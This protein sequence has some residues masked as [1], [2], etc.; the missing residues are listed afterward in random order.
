MSSFSQ[1]MGY[2]P[3]RS[4]VQ[5]E[6][7][8]AETRVAMWNLLVIFREILEDRIYLQYQNDGYLQQ[9]LLA[10]WTYTFKEARDEYPGD[11]KVWQRMKAGVLDFSWFDAL[12]VL[13]NFAKDI[14]R[15]QPESESYQFWEGFAEAANDRF[16]QY[17][18]GYRFIETEITPV[19]STEE[20]EAVQEALDAVG[21]L[22]GARHALTRAVDLLANRQ[23]PDYPNSM[24][25]SISAVESVIRMVS[26]ETD[27][28]A[29][30]KKL[31][32]AGL[33][34]HPALKQAWMKMYGYTSDESGV[35]HG[36]IEAATVDQALAK[37]MLVT[38]SG[39]V[40][41][42]IEEGRKAGLL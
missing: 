24:K 27:L 26:G 41:Y 13:E 32:S 7:L 9:V 3:T 28:A 1:R 12:D 18:V 39:F 2:N 35:R 8:D 36:A 20:S 6:D 31:E 14:K 29:G 16:E 40:S 5:Q 42:L 33:T 37:Y 25:E 17:L 10:M 23:N 21:G 15:L 22:K 19:G 11:A 38:C 30:L 34:I 4:L